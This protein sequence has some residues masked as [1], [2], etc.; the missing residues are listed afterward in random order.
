MKKR[1]LIGAV[2]L[3]VAGSMYGR[4]EAT[5]RYTDYIYDT[6]GERVDVDVSQDWKLTG[7]KATFK[8]E[9]TPL[10]GTYSA[11]TYGDGSIHDDVM[12]AY[13]V[14]E[15]ETTLHDR[16]VTANV[17][18]REE[19]VRANV[20]EDAVRMRDVTTKPEP[21]SI[22]ELNPETFL[23]ASV[24]LHEA[25]N[26]TAE[27]KQRVLDVIRLL[28]D[29]VKSIHFSFDGTPNEDDDF[30]ERYLN[31]SRTPQSGDPSFNSLQTIDDLN[32]HDRLYG[33]DKTTF[34]SEYRFD[35]KKI[36]RDTAD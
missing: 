31:V 5:E 25:W 24:M 32:R 36:E 35:G 11:R 2:G 4:S 29:D 6:Y 8:L 14:K 30:T 23:G 27:Q 19:T 9:T 22:F 21:T 34:I 16:L 13:W 15:A 1:L 7:Y 20:P 28:E 26:D 18:S 3:L 17:L 10:R 12:P 33:F